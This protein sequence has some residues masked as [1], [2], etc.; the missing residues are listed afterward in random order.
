MKYRVTNTTAKPFPLTIDGSA[1]T[2]KVG[3][4][5]SDIEC[6]ERT[7]LRLG[8]YGAVTFEAVAEEKPPRSAAA[9]RS[10]PKPAEAPKPE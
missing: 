9:K 5:D 8:K 6:S 1:V 4:Q 7:A 3:V 10:E 2:L